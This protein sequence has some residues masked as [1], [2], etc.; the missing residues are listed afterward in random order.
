MDKFD[1]IYDKFNITHFPSNYTTLHTTLHYAT[2]NTTL[3]YATHYTTLHY[4]LHYIHK[5]SK[6]TVCTILL[7]ICSTIY[8]MFRPDLLAIFRE[9]YAATF[10]AVHSVL[11]THQTADP[12]IYCIRVWTQNIMSCCCIR[13]HAVHYQLYV[14]YVSQL[15]PDVN[16]CIKCEHYN[17]CDN[18]T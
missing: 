7:F 18:T 13:L 14:L 4:T 3:H 8:K 6:A 9:S 10:T 17:S 15:P 11:T 1:C 16:K 12:I 2:H 5:E